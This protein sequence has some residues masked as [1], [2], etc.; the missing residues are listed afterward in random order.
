MSRTLPR[1]CRVLSLLALVLAG[2]S[3]LRAETIQVPAEAA[4]VQAAADLAEPGDVVLIAK[5]TYTE[6]VSFSGLSGVT[7]RGQGK[8]VFTASAEEGAAP[9][10]SGSFSADVSF[11][12][13]R[14]EGLPTAL[15]ITGSSRIAVR[16]CRFDDGGTAVDFDQVQQSLVAGCKAK[17][18]SVGVR[19]T[20]CTLV[21]VRKNDFKVTG[22]GVN[23]DSST[24]LL[25]RDNKFQGG[26]F[27]VF[28]GGTTSQVDLLDNQV[29]DA[30]NIGLSLAG[31]NHR[32]QGN[33]LRKCGTGIRSS[34]G[35]AHTQYTVA[36]NRV[37]QSGVDGIFLRA[38]SSRLAGNVVKKAGDE[39]IAV[40]A[41]DM[42]VLDNVVAGTGAAGL[43]I[44]GD[45]GCVIGNKVG[46]SGG[47][48]I[49][50]EGVGNMFSENKPSTPFDI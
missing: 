5:G 44:S 2:A 34:L 29:R 33:V 4:T 15:E 36:D 16:D 41:D 20:D 45:S 32:V 12:G 9:A 28:L 25:V 38:S 1:S 37:L 18:M 48:A 10:F 43:R 26:S 30:A 50:V 24:R 22:A 3:N 49:L 42:Q 17:G 11:D 46:K 8:V 13:L 40:D 23:V 47:E 21:V 7:F 35:P 31:D 14:F 6:S 27:G 19:L 39:G